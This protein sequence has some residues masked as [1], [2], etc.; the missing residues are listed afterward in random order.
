MNSFTPTRKM[1]A[2]TELIEKLIK[3]S[4]Y[5]KHKYT[6]IY[7]NIDP[8][9]VNNHL[10]GLTGNIKINRYK[11][12]FTCD[13]TD[14]RCTNM[15]VLTNE[16]KTALDIWFI[17]SVEQYYQLSFSDEQRIIHF[18]KPTIYRYSL[19]KILYSLLRRKNKVQPVNSSAVVACAP[20]QSPPEQSTPEQSPPEQSPPEQYFEEI[21][22]ADSDELPNW[23]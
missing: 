16:Q 12:I 4:M 11:D 9:R 21:E 1:A 6:R 2:E 10:H 7:T 13:N 22:E 17:H 18:S 3:D 23:C 5:T 14:N 19:E 8:D 15:M 20:E